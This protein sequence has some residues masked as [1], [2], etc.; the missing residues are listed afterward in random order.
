MAEKLFEKLSS[1]LKLAK[2]PQWTKS[3]GNMLIGYVLATNFGK[4]DFGL[5]ALGFFAV[6][7]LLWGSL[8]TFNDWSDWQK[9]KMH[10]IKKNRPIPSGQVSPQLA[11]LFAGILL[12][13]AFAIGIYLNNFLFLICLIGMLVNQSLYTFRPFEFKK[14]PIVDL[15]TGSLVNP[16]F[17]FYAGWVL[18][19]PAFN[20][21]VEILLFVIA[22]QFGGYAL[23][24]MSSIPHEKEMKYKSSVVVFPPNTIKTVAYIGIAAG[25][26]GFFAAIYNNMLPQK[27]LWLAVLSLAAFPLYYNTIKNPQKMDLKFAYKTIYLLYA[28]FIIG[29]F[30]VGYYL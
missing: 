26:I 17:R 8:Y 5:F 18:A 1:L 15:V 25:V 24:R 4:F 11:F 3:L 9:D 29:F 2:P 10:P 27:F 22:I 12:A 6:G 23:Y 21:P 7:P 19:V 30:V 13:G 14:K 28:L 20:A 16:F